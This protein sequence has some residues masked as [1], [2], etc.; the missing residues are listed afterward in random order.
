[1]F[2]PPRKPLYWRGHGARSQDMTRPIAIFVAGLALL[3]WGATAVAQDAD[4]GTFPTKPVRLLVPFPPGGAVDIV[5]RTLGDE[6]TR[7]W[8]QQ[9]VIEN[10]PGAGGVI[11]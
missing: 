6:L 3:A 2:I 11:A 8:G 1:M 5:A 10:R 9:V 7:R 4:R